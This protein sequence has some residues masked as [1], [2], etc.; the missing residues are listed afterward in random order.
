M[1][2]IF[3][4]VPHVVAKVVSNTQIKLPNPHA[5]AF[6]APHWPTLP[7]PPPTP[8]IQN[9]N[10]TLCRLTSPSSM[11]QGL[12]FTDLCSLSSQ[13]SPGTQLSNTSDASWHQA[14][15]T[16]QIFGTGLLDPS[17]TVLSD[18]CSDGILPLLKTFPLLPSLLGGFLRF[19]CFD[20][21]HF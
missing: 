19:F 16:P 4:G 5:K 2:V 15:H 6:W 12:W 11:G 13:D 1:V 3:G 10:L 8:T 18:H 17:D 7:T 9:Y 14:E 21:D 20:V